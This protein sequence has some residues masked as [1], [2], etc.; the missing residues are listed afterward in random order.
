M[1]KG[2]AAGKPPTTGTERPGDTRSAPAP[3]AGS[4]AD[5]LAGL[6]EHPFFKDNKPVTVKRSDI[7]PAPYNPRQIDLNAKVKLKQG[8]REYGCVEALVWNKRSGNLVGGHQRLKIADEEVNYPADRP[9]YPVPVMVVD[10]DAADEKTLNVLLN[11]PGAQGWWDWQP[12][13][14]MIAGE[15]G[16]DAELAGF[17]PVLLRAQFEQFTAADDGL[18]LSHVFGAEAKDPAQADADAIRAMKATKE[19]FKAADGEFSKDGFYFQV[20]ARATGEKEKFCAALGY[21]THTKSIELRDLVVRLNKLI[22][23]GEK[24]DTGWVPPPDPG[25]GPKPPEPG[26]APADPP[27]EETADAGTG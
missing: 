2:R 12:L 16:F 20:Q 24:V 25:A 6:K 15:K 5:P 10:L 1:A 27:A 4:A 3:E 8:L 7:K 17:D 13:K 21:S 23:R 9:D 18:D 22:E 26:T 11:N 19:E 14:E